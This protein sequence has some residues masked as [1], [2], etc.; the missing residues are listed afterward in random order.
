MQVGLVCVA[1]FT[2]LFVKI[3]KFDMY[4]IFLSNCIE[5]VLYCNSFTYIQKY[6]S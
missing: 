1:M 6:F 3:M 2:K 5:A 4:R